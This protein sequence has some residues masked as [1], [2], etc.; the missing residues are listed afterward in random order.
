MSTPNHQQ[1]TLQ[2]AKKI[3]NKF[4]CL[5]I[6]PILKPSEKVVTSEALIFGKVLVLI[7]RQLLFL[8]YVH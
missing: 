4:N 5:D 6:A 8:S 2:E 1:L 7:A 3:L